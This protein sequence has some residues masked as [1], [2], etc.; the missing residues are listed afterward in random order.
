MSRH[1]KIGLLIEE[2]HNIFRGILIKAAR[3]QKTSFVSGYMSMYKQKTTDGVLTF[4][5]H[6]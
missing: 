4:T 5:V 1:L 6:R 3:I 2:R